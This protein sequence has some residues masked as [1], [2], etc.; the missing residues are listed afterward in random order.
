MQYLLILQVSSLVLFKCFGIVAPLTTHSTSWKMCWTT[1]CTQYNRLRRVS[2]LLKRQIPPHFCSRSNLHVVHRATPSVEAHVSIST[3]NGSSAS[4]E[5]ISPIMSNS[6]AA[7]KT[8]TIHVANST[9]PTMALAASSV[10]I[11]VLRVVFR[12]FKVPILFLVSYISYMRALWRPESNIPR[13]VQVVRVNRWLKELDKVLQRGQL[14]DGHTP[15]EAFCSNAIETAKNKSITETSSEMSTASAIAEI[16]AACEVLQVALDREMEEEVANWDK[17]LLIRKRTL[18]ELGMRLLT[19]WL[20]GISCTAWIFSGN[21]GHALG[22]Y[23]LAIVAQLEYYR[24]VIATGV[25]PARRIGIVTTTA[26]YACACFAPQL[27]QLVLPLSATAVMVWFLVMRPK[28]ATIGEI[29]SSFM[30]IFYVGYLPSFWVRLRTISEGLPV[31]VTSVPK[32]AAFTRLPKD[33]VTQGAVVKWWV[34]FTIVCSDVAAYFGGRAFGRT[35]LSA[36]G[37]GAAGLTSPNKT[38]EGVISGL[39][40]SGLV[41]ALGARLMGCKKWQHTGLI[42]GMMLGLIAFVG[43][44]TAS[45]FKRD[46]GLKVR[47]FYYEHSLVPSSFHDVLL[48]LATRMRNP[49]IC[50]SLKSNRTSGTSFLD[51]AEFS[52][53]STATSLPVHLSTFQ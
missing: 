35:P 27:H 12:P 53:A 26:M 23:L 2:S 52:T 41:S 42:F 9:D 32:F 48:L 47:A 24:S 4:N 51:M 10:V 18:N 15:S 49:S 21:F 16:R 43:D 31:M 39:L 3:I 11:H 44:L 30:G 19:G 50:F 5:T 37:R 6:G 14:G 22:L 33:L 34:C 13:T 25:Y 8:T 28:P 20:L 45:M 1:K 36:L 40:A 29:S 38:V 17:K 46:A 7:T